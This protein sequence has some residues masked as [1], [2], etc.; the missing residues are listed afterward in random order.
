MSLFSSHAD[1]YLGVDFGT[2]SIKVIE[3]HVIKDKPHLANYGWVNVTNTKEVPDEYDGDYAK[4]LNDALKVLFAQMKPKTHKA[5]VAIP[6][7][8]GLVMIVDFPRMSEKEVASAIKFESRKYIPASLEEVNVSWEILDKEEK[9]GENKPTMQ[10]LL[11]AAPK[12]E[13]QYYDSLF[14]GVDVKIDSL[15]LESFSVVRSI[16]GNTA[17]RF[18]LVDIGAKTTNIVLVEDT[19]VHVSRSVDIGGADMTNAVMQSMNITRERAI[20]LKEGGDNFFTGPT[21]VAFPSLNFIVNEIKRVLSSQKSDVIESLVL[22]GGG[23]ELV[24]LPEYLGQNTGLKVTMGNPLSHIIC[25]E[26][27]SGKIKE[28]RSSFAVAIGLAL[29]SME[30]DAK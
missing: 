27:N 13:V 5:T 4:R 24:G 23:A 15:E 12:S 21:R 10:V 11:V 30:E 28:L 1:S 22:C 16:I 25:D 26:N 19:I 14:E 29:R 17:G 8:N 2:Q 18:L 6:S 9:E 7:F 3:L 20:A